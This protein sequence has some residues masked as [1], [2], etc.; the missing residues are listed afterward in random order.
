MLEVLERRPRGDARP[1]SLLFVHGAWHAAWCWND[2]FLDFFAN[3]GYRS[4]ALSLRGHG[5]S[6]VSQPLR[7]CSIADYVDDVAAVADAMP[8]P[9]V[10]I[11]HSMGGFVVQKYLESRDAPGGVLLASAPPGGAIGT[12]RK[13]IQRHPWLTARGLVT[14]RTVRNVNTPKLAREHFF[15][16]RT[17]EQ[18]VTACAARLQE[19]SARALF[20]GLMFRELPRPQRVTAPMLVLGAERDGVI[21]VKDVQA[22]A[23]A[24][25]T[26][27]E[28]FPDMGHD[29]MLEP[30]W[31]AVA[32]RIHSWLGARLAQHSHHKT[33]YG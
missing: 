14:G 4:V 17:P 26:D 2:H 30:G 10:L 33:R 5:A 31:Y 8:T 3:N 18:V 11:G 12:V 25:D 20:L 15:C 22:T 13:A 7:R 1:V 16:A 29:M 28:F 32:A 24:Y 9:P 27:A 19:E 23:R 6:T 21:S